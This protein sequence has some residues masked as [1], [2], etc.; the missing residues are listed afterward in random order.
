LLDD[1]GGELHSQYTLTYSPTGT[2]TEGYH[3]I[4]VTVDRKDITVRARPGYYLAGPGG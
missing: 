2:N 3:E 4:S 1:I